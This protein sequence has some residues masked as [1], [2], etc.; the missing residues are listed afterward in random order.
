MDMRRGFLLVIP[1]V[2]IALA[3]TTLPGSAQGRVGGGRGGGGRGGGAPAPVV[4][5]GPIPRTA[6]GKP[7][8]RGVFSGMGAGLTHTVILEEHASGF[9]IRGGKS[10]IIDPPDGKIPY[11]PAALV[12]RD[13]R[14]EDVNAYEDPVGHCE[15]YDIGRL[16]SFAQRFM[17]TQ[18]KIVIGAQE[19][20]MRNIYMDRKHHLPD[21]IRLWLGDSI[22]WWESDT[23]VV[24]TTNFNGKTRM[25]LGGD[26]YSA[27][28]HVVERFTMKDSETITWTMTITDPTVFSRPWTFTTAAP[29]TRQREGSNDWNRALRLLDPAWE[30]DCHEGNV[31]L[32][33]MQNVYEQAHGKK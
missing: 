8:L 13:R 18:N 33:H 11:L 14:R 28:A 15:F 21:S 4:T 25:A 17:Y 2:A 29:M 30:H 9:G 20:I 3:A 24:E 10:L 12:E 27:N 1:A 19:Q 22:G 7:D 6:D 26:Y 23:L 31:V 5:P 16:H 32:K